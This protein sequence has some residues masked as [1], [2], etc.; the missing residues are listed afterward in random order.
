M[1]L[2]RD[3]W[4]FGF[5]LEVWKSFFDYEK[6]ESP[7]LASLW[8]PSLASF[9]VPVW[10]SDGCFLGPIDGLDD[11]PWKKSGISFPKTNGSHLKING[12]SGF[13]AMLVSGSVH[14]RKINGW[15]LKIIPSKRNIIWTK[16]SLHCVPAL[17]F[18]GLWSQENSKL[19]GYD[20]TFSRCSCCSSKKLVVS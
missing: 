13:P 18:P 8:S 10:W 3:E 2:G 1:R 4:N 7:S 12:C 6:I 9:V 11:D 20:S 19:L 5:F 15:N 17:T 16:P 14:P